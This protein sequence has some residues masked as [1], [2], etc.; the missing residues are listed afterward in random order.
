MMSLGDTNII[1]NS[2]KE[3]S[4]ENQID[5]QAWLVNNMEKE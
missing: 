4:Q 1:K 3:V 2:K 5:A